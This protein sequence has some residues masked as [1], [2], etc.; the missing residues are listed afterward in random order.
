MS[1]TMTVDTGSHELVVAEPRHLV[2][3][4]A[5]AAIDWERLELEARLIASHPG[6]AQ[7]F[8]D[9]VACR[10]VAYKAQRWG[11]DPVATAEKTYFTPRK[12]GGLNVGYE[13]QLVHAIV[14]GDPDLLAPLEITF[15]YSDPAKRVA[16]LRFCKVSGRIR[17]APLPAI[18]ISPT[19]GQIKTKNSPLWWS[20][21]DQQLSY[22]SVRAW[23]RRHRPGRLLGI[24]SRDEIETMAERKPRLVLFEEEDTADADFADAVPPGTDAATE[25]TSDAPDNGVGRAPPPDSAGNDP[26]DLA[27][28]RAWGEAERVRLIALTDPAEVGK[29]G[30]AMEQDKRWRR[31]KAYSQAYT[32]R[33]VRSLKSRIDELE[34]G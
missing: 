31:L 27:D 13:A 26:P 14:Q 19:I 17:G 21:P 29:G 12:D 30:A 33:I 1:E 20:D 22:M 28:L 7:E 8:K 23:A 11:T 5:G 18:Y 32:Q 9:P 2:L 3:A 10:F 25:A 6:L 24:Y 16:Q 4:D 15:G 34:A